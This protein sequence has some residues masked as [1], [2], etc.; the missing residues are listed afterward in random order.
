MYNLVRQAGKRLYSYNNKYS[1]TSYY[2]PHIVIAFGDILMSKIVS[3]LPSRTFTVCLQHND[4]ISHTHDGLLSCLTPGNGRTSKGILFA[5]GGASEQ[6]A[7]IVS[8]P[9]SFPSLCFSN[10]P[11]FALAVNSGA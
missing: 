2:V 6:E 11:H 7:R 3:S 5:G 9:C 10:S 4:G 1:L 8:T